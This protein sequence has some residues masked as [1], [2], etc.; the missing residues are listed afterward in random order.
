M[1]NGDKT[2]EAQFTIPA[3]PNSKEQNWLLIINTAAKS[4]DDII[5]ADK[6]QS[7]KPGSILKVANMGLIVLQGGSN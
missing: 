5:D 7:V 6:A 3:I 1:I 4:P 2:S